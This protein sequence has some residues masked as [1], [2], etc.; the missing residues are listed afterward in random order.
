MRVTFDPVRDG[1]AAINSVADKLT[2]AQRQLASGRRV[3][4]VSDD[5]QAV[6][7]AIGAHAELGALDAYRRSGDSAAGRLHAADAAL[8]ALVDKLTSASAVVHGARGSSAT[9][10]VRRA[11]AVQVRALRDGIASDLNTSFNGTYLFSGT[12]TDAPAYVNSGG[13]SYQG[14][15]ATVDVAID[16]GRLVSVTFDGRAIAQ[17]ADAVDLFTA[18]DTLAAALEANDL[19]AIAQGAEA[20]ERAFDRAAVAQGRLGAADRSVTE[21]GLRLQS[22]RLATE[23]QRAK[24]EDADVAES[25]TRMNQADTAYRATLGAVSAAERQSLLDYLR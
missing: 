22:L 12:R 25:I 11:A 1:L 14:D 7:Q 5:P 24:L 18:L 17:G 8:G 9:D 23:A 19:T 3:N 13:W 4:Q 20:I 15:A 16:R 2:S 6:R 10:D 21:S